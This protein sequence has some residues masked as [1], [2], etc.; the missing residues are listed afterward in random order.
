MVILPLPKAVHAGA[1]YQRIADQQAQQRAEQEEQQDARAFAAEQAAS[2][3]DAHRDPLAGPSVAPSA[4]PASSGVPL[5][6]RLA[7]ATPTPEPGRCSE[8][9]EEDSDGDGVNNFDE[10]V[11]GT[12]SSGA[13]ALDFD[14]DGLTDAQEFIRLGTSATT[15]DTDGDGITDYVEVAGFDYAGQHWYSDP[16]NADTNNDGRLDTLEC[17]DLTGV[18]TPPAVTQ[19]AC[20]NDNDT[21]PD[22]FDG[23]DDNDRVP[24]RTDLSPTG[25]VGRNGKSHEARRLLLRC[26]ESLP[27]LRA[28]PRR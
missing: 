9:T 3:W 23:D 16:L 20:D 27:S 18:A 22:M 12:S 21:I 17:P 14:A 28:E 19:A 25:L 11:I 4:P 2:T 1:F 24:D 7:T 10:C 8:Y 6:P 5:V 26:Q 13:N 15:K